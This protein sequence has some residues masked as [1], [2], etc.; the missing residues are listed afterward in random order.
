MRMSMALKHVRL[1]TMKMGKLSPYNFCTGQSA[2]LG[3]SMVQL[4]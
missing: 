3:M 1:Q 4:K 2:K